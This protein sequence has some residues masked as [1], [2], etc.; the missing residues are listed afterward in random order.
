M[1]NKGFTMVE[2]LVAA[3]IMATLT[4]IMMPQYR[5]A[6]SRSKVAEAEQ[7]LPALFEARERWV[8]EHGCTWT[9]G[10]LSG[11]DSS[12]KVS[13]L[14]IEVTGAITESDNLGDIKIQ[15]ENFKYYLV[16]PGT[17]AQACVSAEPLFGSQFGMTEAVIY[18]RGDK[19]SCGMK[20][21]A[22]KNGCG[23]I[24]VDDGS[25]AGSCH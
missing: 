2:L 9:G 4:A 13:K 5:K 10:G 18:Y 11:C 23:L 21:G 1:Q 24:N 15:T 17:G 6:V 14:D 20:D 12:L 19:F 3:M 22:E 16:V 8:L 25:G 7:V